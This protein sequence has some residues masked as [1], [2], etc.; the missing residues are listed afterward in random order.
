MNVS[1]YRKQTRQTWADT[2]FPENIC[3]WWYRSGMSAAIHSIDNRLD[4]VKKALFYGKDEYMEARVDEETFEDLDLSRGQKDLLHAV[5]GV[6][7][8]AGELMEA[9]DP[10]LDPESDEQLDTINIDEEMGDL[11]YYMMRMHDVLE[12]MPQSTMKRNL[13]KLLE[14]YDEGTFSTED[15]LNRDKIQERKVLES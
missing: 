10:L 1:D 13:T 12:T 9:I 15:A 2:W 14:R 7:T 6:A 8:E 11:Y 4:E 3:V 5:L